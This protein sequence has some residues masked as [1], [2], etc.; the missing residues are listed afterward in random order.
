VSVLCVVCGVF[1]VFRVSGVSDGVRRDSTR[2][3]VLNVFTDRASAPASSWRR[4][5]IGTRK[6]SHIAMMAA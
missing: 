2:I 5:H 6:A 3:A 1:G 4:S